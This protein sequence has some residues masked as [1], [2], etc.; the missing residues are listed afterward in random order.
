MPPP[1][2]LQTMPPP[3]PPWTMPPPLPPRAMSPML[4]P[5]KFS[6]STPS[7]L[8]DKNN[9]LSKSMPE[10]VPVMY[11]TCSSMSF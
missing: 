5:P 2:P 3:P 7:K 6:S 10:S 4:P 8:L 11:V 9:V 1:P